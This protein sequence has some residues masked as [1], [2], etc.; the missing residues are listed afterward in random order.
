V[1]LTPFA[2]NFYASTPARDSLQIKF[3]LQAGWN[4]Q[5]FEPN[6]QGK[7]DHELNEGNLD[8]AV[9]YSSSQHLDMI[10]I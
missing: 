3:L 2:R 10:A 7:V 4:L 6:P 8:K 1:N 5:F 9:F